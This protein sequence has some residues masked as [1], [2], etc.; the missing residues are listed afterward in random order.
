VTVSLKYNFCT[1]DASQTGSPH[2][3]V[4]NTVHFS[5]ATSLHNS[6]KRQLG[7]WFPRRLISHS[8]RN[9]VKRVAEEEGE[10]V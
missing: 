1:A 5:M 4:G 3:D 6:T 9:A 10:C 7:H 2:S 8:C